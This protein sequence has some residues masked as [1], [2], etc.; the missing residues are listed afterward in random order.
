MQETWRCPTTTHPAGTSTANAILAA[1]TGTPAN[2]AHRPATRNRPRRAG[3]AMTGTRAG[4][5]PP[6]IGSAADR[7]G[8]QQ[9]RRRRWRHRTR[10]FAE[11][12]WTGNSAGGGTPS[13]D[14]LARRDRAS[15][16]G[17]APARQVEQARRRQPSQ[18]R[19]HPCLP[20]PRHTPR[21][22]RPM[23]RSIRAIRYSP[24]RLAR[25]R[26]PAKPGQ[27]RRPRPHTSFGPRRPVHCLPQRGTTLRQTTPPV[28]SV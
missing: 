28:C 16:A 14:G 20:L 5:T 10:G 6:A 7:A 23:R 1:T 4:A 2:A 11:P 24:H 19:H 9:T 18:Q 15:L 17:D 13:R 22:I 3:L 25:P 26:Q 12:P 27:P 21:R 8:R